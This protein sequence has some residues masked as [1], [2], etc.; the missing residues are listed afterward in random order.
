[1]LSYWNL[2]LTGSERLERTGPDDMRSVDWWSFLDFW[3]RIRMPMTEPKS[4][5]QWTAM[6]TVL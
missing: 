3:I 6:R 4:K 1:M 2:S 5:E